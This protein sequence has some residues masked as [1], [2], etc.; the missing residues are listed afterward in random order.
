MGLSLTGAFHVLTLH[1][2]LLKRCHFCHDLRQS[3]LMLSL[4]TQFSPS[5]L[6]RGCGLVVFVSVLAINTVIRV[7]L[8]CRVEEHMGTVLGPG[9]LEVR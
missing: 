7:P 2:F 8:L 5:L 1:S 4:H 9:M 6:S 3:R